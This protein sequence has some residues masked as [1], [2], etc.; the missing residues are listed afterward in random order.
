[1]SVMASEKVIITDT[2]EQDEDNFF[3][4]AHVVAKGWMVWKV[5]ADSES[6]FSDEVD[7]GSV[8]MNV[9]AKGLA[10]ELS[11]RLKRNVTFV[12][13]AS[14]IRYL[15]RKSGVTVEGIP[16]EPDIYSSDDDRAAA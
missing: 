5:P 14:G 6:S 16:S 3:P 9:V 2:S 11:P 13:Q 1:M 8:A 7:N 10:A 15:V 4:A 12:F